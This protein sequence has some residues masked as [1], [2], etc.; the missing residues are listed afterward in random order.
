M[1]DLPAHF[2]HSKQPFVVTSQAQLCVQCGH[3]DSL[4]S[5][6]WHSGLEFQVK[7]VI[8]LTILSFCIMQC[9]RVVQN[10][11]MQDRLAHCELCSRYSPNTAGNKNPVTDYP[12]PKSCFSNL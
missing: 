3:N 5:H 10:L 4:Q 11:Q 2:P 7:P 6:I 12:L 1:K 8:N 9:C